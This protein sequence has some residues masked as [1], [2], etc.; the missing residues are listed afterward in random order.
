MN[1]SWIYELTQLMM[2]LFIP[3]LLVGIA[4]MFSERGG[5]TNLA[6]E[7]MMILG[8][9]FGVYIV[10]VIC[11]AM[12]VP[13]DQMAAATNIIT[14]PGQRTLIYIAAM[15]CSIVL[16]IIISFTLSWA[17]NKLHADQVIVGTAINIIAPAI[18]LFLAFSLELA[19]RQTDKL[20]IDLGLFQIP[21]VPGLGD[22]P[23]VGQ[24]LFQNTYPSL[25]IGLILWVVA[26]IVMNKTRFGLRLTAAGENPYALAAAGLSVNK[27]R[28][29]GTAI[30]GAIAAYAGFVYATSASTTTEFN[31]SVAGFG[32][33]GLAI[34]IFGNW[35]PSLIGVAAL[36]FS[37]FQ[38]IGIGYQ[39][40]PG[41]NN[42]VVP[43]YFFNMLPFL[44]TLVVLVVF[45]KKNRAPKYDGVPYYA[46]KR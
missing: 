21:S 2:K 36:L 22:I 24:A 46:E 29:M 34:M 44:I 15:L 4:G 25:F 11:Q 28:Y 30:S 41:S 7:G 8:G 20:N 18:C 13:L 19:G 38:T 5:I 26:I 6:L 33:L 35:K 39:F 10:N 37:I 42:W 43:A 17:A 9:F 31:S 40:I 14:D 1:Y 23:Y 16:G 12:G 3:L 45:S 32:F 27:Y